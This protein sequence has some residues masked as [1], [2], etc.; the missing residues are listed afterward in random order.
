MSE[1]AMPL[2]PKLAWRNILFGEAA[3]RPRVTKGAARAPAPS[4]LRKA[5]RERDA[6]ELMWVEGLEA[7]D[8]DVAEHDGIVVARETKMA[9]RPVLARMLAVGH[10][11][12][13]L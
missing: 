8:G 9:R 11:I 7:F 6:C 10:V 2:V 12:A 13:D 4:C 3:I 5:R 1:A